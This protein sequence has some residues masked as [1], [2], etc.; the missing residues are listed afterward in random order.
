MWIDSIIR[1]TPQ[2]HAKTIQRLKPEIPPQIEKG[3]YLLKRSFLG[4]ISV[5]RGVDWPS[6]NKFTS[7][8]PVCKKEM[9]AAPL[10]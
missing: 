5:F 8:T 4:C 7:W 1:V 3:N 6:K 2:K 9:P 10:T